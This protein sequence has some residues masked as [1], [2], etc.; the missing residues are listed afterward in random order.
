MLARTITITQIH[1]QCLRSLY[2][3]THKT[4][5]YLSTETWKSLIYKTVHVVL[6]STWIFLI[7][8]PK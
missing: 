3:H 2:M 1:R 7:S 5:F 6:S 8:M 4:P